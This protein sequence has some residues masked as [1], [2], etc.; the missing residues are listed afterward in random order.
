MH[1]NFF[2]LLLWL[3]QGI[4]IKLIFKTGTN[5]EHKIKCGNGA[6]ILQYD[7]GYSVS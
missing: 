4:I 5:A 1:L 3:N 2:L 7:S 6:T